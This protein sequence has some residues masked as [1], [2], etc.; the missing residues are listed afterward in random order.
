MTG[1]RMVQVVS[2]PGDIGWPTQLP[3]DARSSGCTLFGHGLTRSLLNFPFAHWPR[4][5]YCVWVRPMYLS[6]S[7]FVTEFEPE[8]SGTMGMLLWK[9]RWCGSESSFFDESRK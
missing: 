1:F 2:M 9:S 8:L 7:S 3:A 4:R 5:K 6:W